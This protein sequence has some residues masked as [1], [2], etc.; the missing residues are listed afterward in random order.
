MDRR[1][2]LIFSQYELRR[3]SK[4]EVKPFSCNDLSFSELVM[5]FI[6]SNIYIRISHSISS[7]EKKIKK[8]K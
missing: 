8:H 7:G 3:T 5:N 4:P 2:F 1:C 6:K